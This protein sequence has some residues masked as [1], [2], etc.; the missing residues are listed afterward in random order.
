MDH[1]RTISSPGED[2]PSRSA[3]ISSTATSEIE[4]SE[5]MFEA[6]Y[7]G[8]LDRGWTISLPSEDVPSSSA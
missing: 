8:N 5:Q 7:F 3:C 2:V 6:K 1:G 4:L